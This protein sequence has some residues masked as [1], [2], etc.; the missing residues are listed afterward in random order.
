[1]P[2]V[3]RADDHGIDILVLQCFAIVAVSFH[4]VVWL[5]SLLCIIIIDEFFRILYPVTIEIANCNNARAIV[6]PDI[7][8][9]MVARYSPRAKRGDVDPVAGSI[10]S[11][12]G[13]GNDSWKSGEQQ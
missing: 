2:V 3:G 11:Q 8:H 6:L 5:A 4:A 13:G 10:L 9:V 7:R 12:D 1:M